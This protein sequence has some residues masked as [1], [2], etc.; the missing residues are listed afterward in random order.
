[1]KIE[2]DHRDRQQLHG[3][4]ERNRQAQHTEEH[5]QRAG[6]EACSLAQ[7]RAD[8]TETA[9]NIGVLPRLELPGE[10]EQRTDQH[11]AAIVREAEPQQ[12]AGRERQ[13][14]RGRRI[15]DC[16]RMPTL[17]Q[18]GFKSIDRRHRDHVHHRFGLAAAGRFQAQL[19]DSED[20]MQRIAL[21]HDVLDARIRNMALAA[22]EDAF[23]DDQLVAAEVVAKTDAVDQRV[24]RV[25][26]RADDDEPFPPFAA[27]EEQQH[28][29]RQYDRPQLRQ[30]HEQP[31]KRVQPM[32]LQCGHDRL[33][34]HRGQRVRATDRAAPRR[35]RARDRRRPARRGACPRCRPSVRRYRNGAQSVPARLPYAGC[36]SAG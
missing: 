13:Q 6:D 5:R 35:R 9:A 18:H 25:A 11:A 24:H 16:R 7:E 26:E 22:R 34:G 4:E 15:R 12:V 17:V 23:L 19:G 3:D 29:H 31:G 20:A 30:Q 14:R 1:M 8:D 27:T 36:A 32:A 28:Q 21:T 10:R 33:R 2:H